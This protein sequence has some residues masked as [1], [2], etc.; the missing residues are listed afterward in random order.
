VFRNTALFLVFYGCIVIL[1]DCGVG[2]GVK[3]NA[4]DQK[5]NQNQ[6]SVDD[7][8]KIGLKAT[9]TQQLQQVRRQCNV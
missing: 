9:R 3:L 2:L 1:A 5:Q 6:I 4:K 8:Q 7:A